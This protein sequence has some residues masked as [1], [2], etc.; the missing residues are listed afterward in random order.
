MSGSLTSRAA[1]RAGLVAATAAGAGMG[2]LVERTLLRGRLDVPPPE[3]PALGSIEGT[4]RI[5]RGPDGTRVLVES[6][7]P[8]RAGAPQIVCS[9]GWVCTGR[10]WHE[11][12]MGLA[13]RWRVVTYD[14]P[15]HG[16]TSSPASGTYDMDL[17][18]DTL[19]TVVAEATLPGPVVLC[20]HSL[21]GMAILNFAR[22]HPQLLAERVTGALLMSTTASTLLAS[23]E[24]GAGGL[25]L[26]RV[27]RGVEQLL[28]LGGR[29]A[30][31]VA[32]RVYRASSD[33]SF[34]LTRLF[35][36]GPAAEARYVDF[37]EQLLLDSD[38]DMITAVAAPILGLDDREAPACLRVPTIVIVGGADRLTPISA[39]RQLVAECPAAELV[40]LPGIGHM[41]PLEAA[42]TITALLERLCLDGFRDTA[43]SSRSSTTVTTNATT[44]T[45]ATT[46]TR[47]TDGTGTR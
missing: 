44:M 14:Q 31:T 10:V 15:G 6:Y 4:T 37:T 20:G 35:G 17:F 16:R 21:G 46:I 39:A 18:G 13:D 33:L 29:R 9:H 47:G 7:G 5:L 30:A 22:R 1:V 25:V 11:Q 34:A 24:L 41:T 36:L 42:H 3:G 8:E 2:Y 27:E 45:T 40:V 43:A 26:A 28:A 38:L 23:A 19:A 12:V 32:D